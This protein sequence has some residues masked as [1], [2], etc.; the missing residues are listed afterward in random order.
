[1]TAFADLVLTG[2]SIWVGDGTTAE[3]LAV[4]DGTIVSLHADEVRE[5]TGPRTRV[6]HRPGAL[7]V[8]GFQDCHVH[9]PPAGR[10]RLTI[11]LHDLP[12]R[13]AYLDTIADYVAANP[14]VEW[15]TGGGWALEHFP[16]A[17]PRREDLDAV[18]GE[19]PA[20]LF[21]RDVHGA[22]VNTAALRRAGIDASTPDPSDGRYE[23]DDDGMPRGMLHEGAAYTFEI[24]WVPQPTRAEWEAAILYAQQHFYALGITG[25]QD[26]WVTAETFAAYAALAASGR[27]TA[28]V[29]GALWWDRHR[30]LDQIELFRGQREQL[31]APFHPTT[32]KI[33]VDGIIENQ[34]AAMI[35]PYC[36]GCG[37]EGD[38]HGLDYV[39]RDVLIAAVTELDSLGFQVHMH[40]IGDRAI[41][42]ALDAVAAARAANGPSDNRHH[43]AHLQ[44]IQP[45]DL[46]RFAELDVVANC[47]TYWAQTEPQMD[48]LTIPFIGRDR[49]ELQ[50]PFAALHA[51]G[52]RLAMGSDWAV[53]T[54]DPLQQMEVA[55]RRIDPENRDN[56][57][58]LPEQALPLDVALSAFTAGSAYTNHDADGGALTVGKRAD[59]AVLD[60]DITSLSG[61]LSDASVVCTVASGAVV[62][63]DPDS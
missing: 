6:L 20:F 8:P 43:I 18:T 30:G 3:A 38:N 5:L 36:A 62:Y 27:L 37:P 33:M 61:L 19:R 22:W 4:R 45:E 2:T 53:T 34:T 54:A 63:G 26:A 16:N 35:Q 13:Q 60:E 12:G 40:A 15:I 25:F 39:D 10:E 11:D 31:H 41:R 7:V 51:A 47:Q 42:N 29:V 32:V 44:V 59:F 9:A 57:P 49:A 17:A 23:R 56:A 50:Y 55:V 21:N 52:A 46:P 24:R 28:R 14:G 58:F 1:V 48:E